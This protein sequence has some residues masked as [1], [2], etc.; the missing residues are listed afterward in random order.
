MR[1]SSR[2]DR[3]AHRR[4]RGG[5]VVFVA[6]LSVCVVMQPLFAGAFLTHSHGGEGSHTH[7]V[8]LQAAVAQ[9]SSSSSSKHAHGHEHAHHPELNRALRHAGISAFD[10]EI[11]VCDADFLLMRTRARNALPGLE[12]GARRQLASGSAPTS[13]LNPDVTGLRSAPGDGPRLAQGRPS[14]N[15]AAL[16]RV[17]PALLL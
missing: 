14:K 8:P 2:H 6:A 7:R 1:A 12:F 16:V 13:W 17:S 9:T 3:S 11:I 5:V 10:G 15:T 4:S